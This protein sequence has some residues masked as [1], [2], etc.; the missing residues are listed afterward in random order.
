[1][2]DAISAQQSERERIL[3]KPALTLGPGEVLSG[4]QV[5]IWSSPATTQWPEPWLGSVLGELRDLLTLTQGWDSYGGAAVDGEVAANVISILNVLAREQQPRP[6]L[7]PTSAGGIQVEW[8][9]SDI[10]LQLEVE[11]SRS[12]IA[13]F[14][15]DR[16]TGA[17][18]E[19][20]FG[21]E[22]EPLDVLLWRVALS[23]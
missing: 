3:A 9:T 12:A 1:M 8:Y 14:Y 13:I 17:S 20:S 11:P 4:K 5:V 19:G 21:D 23:T 15:C 22:P 7:V 16:T 10:E 2:P 18:W 6:T